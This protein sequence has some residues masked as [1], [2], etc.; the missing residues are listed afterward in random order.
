[1]LEYPP[2]PICAASKTQKQSMQTI[3][4]KAL[5]F[6]NYNEE[7][8]PNAEELRL[9]Y[10]ITPLNIS[11]HNKARKIWE[12]VRATEPE[13]YNNLIMP[14]NNQHKWFP[15]TSTVIDTPYVY[16]ILT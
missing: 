3:L 4:N 11:I 16:A 7:D 13:H 1:M 9:R 6:I 10:D 2:I 8:R 5:R 15:I 12:C 14:Q